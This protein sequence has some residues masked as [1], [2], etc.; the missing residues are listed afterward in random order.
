MRLVSLVVTVKG[1]T[2]PAKT[3]ACFALAAVVVSDRYTWATGR[4]GPARHD[5]GPARHVT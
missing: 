2:G 3:A 5:N 4:P 1:W